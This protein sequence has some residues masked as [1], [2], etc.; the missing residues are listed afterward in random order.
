MVQAEKKGENELPSSLAKRIRGLW[1]GA[2]KKS[3]R[4]RRSLK[5]KPGTLAF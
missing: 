2:E 1:S 3:P 4:A 5:K